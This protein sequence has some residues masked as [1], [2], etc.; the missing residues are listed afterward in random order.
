ME[1][2]IVLVSRCCYQSSPLKVISQLSRNGIG[3]KTRAKL[4]L[5]SSLVGFDLS[6]VSRIRLLEVRLSV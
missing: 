1:G 2:R 6:V 4:S 3:W 5:S